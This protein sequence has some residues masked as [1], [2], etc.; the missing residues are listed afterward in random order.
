MKISG[1]IEREDLGY[2]LVSSGDGWLRVYAV[3]R[4]KRRSWLPSYTHLGSVALP[5]RT[6]SARE[7]FPGEEGK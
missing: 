2:K 5:G 7:T 6:E 1:D 3:Y 4:E